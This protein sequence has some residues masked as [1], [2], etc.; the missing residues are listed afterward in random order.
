MT[1]N[2]RISLSFDGQC[3]AAFRFYEQFLG[4]KIAFILTWGNSPMAKD[5]PPGWGDKILHARIT[6]GD[7]DLLGA[8]ALPHIYQPRTGFGILLSVDDSNDTERLFAALAENGKVTA[9]LQETFWA[10]RYGA[11]TDR[12]GVPWE[13]NCEKNQ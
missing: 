13:I 2:P 10:L 11:V 6:I 8:D 7:T 9:P 1:L 3:E 5:A 4:G 12:F